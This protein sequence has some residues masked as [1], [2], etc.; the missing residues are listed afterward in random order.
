VSFQTLSNLQFDFEIIHKINESKEIKKEQIFELIED[1]PKQVI[2]ETASKL[3]DKNKGK[4]VSFSKKAFF[5]IINL[6]R[7]TCSYCT[8]KAEPD[9]TKL[10]L[11]DEQTVKKLAEL[12]K[13]YNCTEALFV[14]GERPE[15]KYQEAK[16]WLRKQGF[17]S[18]TE[19]L[20]HCSEI[21]LKQGVF[22]HTNAGNLTKNEMK[23]LAKTNVSMGV[24]LENSSVRLREDGMPHQD[25]PSKEPLA[26]LNILKNAGELKIPMTTGILV[27]IGETLEECIQSI[28]DIKKIH[29]RYGN[30]QEIILQNFHPKPKTS[31]FE[32]STP[33]ESYFKMVVALCR[34]IMP[35]ANIQ[36]PPNLSPDNYNEFLSV[37][38]NDWGGISPITS[39]YVNPEFSWPN[40]Q[41][42]EKKCGN[43][44]FSLKA[45][46]PV[47]PEFVPLINNDL[48]QRIS[49]IADEKNYVKESYWK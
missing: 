4:V 33:E 35:D 25:A 26:R 39:D 18:T 2:F 5:N 1:V 38:I 23:E 16:E 22:P 27:G 17:S 36:I 46:F 43:L 41:N 11:M 3:R 24:M 48:K 37:G 42:V 20:I 32:H 6:C 21:V 12:A 10:S 47:Y 14:T 28:Y 34:I 7:D 19:Y 9:D 8:Y 40:I 13:K 15:Q 29:Q 49:L 31:M 45:R 44:G 30:I